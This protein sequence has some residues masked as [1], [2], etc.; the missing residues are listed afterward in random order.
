MAHLDL[1]PS[2][3]AWFAV[4]AVRV[5]PL[6]ACLSGFACGDYSEAEVQSIRFVD[7]GDICLAASR[8]GTEVR[9]Q[10]PGCLDDGCF[11]RL[12]AECEVAV[13]GSHIVVSSTISWSQDCVPI[14]FEPSDCIVPEVTCP[15][16]QTL[17][18]GTYTFDYG[19]RTEVLQYGGFFDCLPLD[20]PQSEVP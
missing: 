15:V 10:V 14:V 18:A 19:G 4:W 7:D 9:I 1:R 17:P 5:L 3:R 12:E 11:D 13:D 20:K 6:G 16:D 8:E 2:S